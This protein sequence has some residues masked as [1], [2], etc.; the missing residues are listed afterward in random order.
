[1]KKFLALMVLVC[2]L[3][4]ITLWLCSNNGLLQLPY[5]FWVTPPV[6]FL[7]S[8]SVIHYFLLNATQGRPQKFVNVFIA[9]L[10][11]K[12][13]MH[14][15]I[16]VAVAFSFRAYAFQFIIV[17]ALNYLAFTAAETASLLKVFYKKDEIA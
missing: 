4:L 8:S 15:L 12:M 14:L 11:F 2:S 5:E 10:S 6:F 13:F 9:L 7:A 3:S 16:L 17:Y 1:M